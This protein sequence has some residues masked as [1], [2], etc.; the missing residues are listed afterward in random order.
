MLQ[1][2]S[3]GLVK[4]TDHLT[5]MFREHSDDLLYTK[6]LRDAEEKSLFDQYEEIRSHRPK[7]VMGRDKETG[8]PKAVVTGL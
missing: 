1:V 2:L 3:Q 7:I 4:D 6:S 5:R 8:K